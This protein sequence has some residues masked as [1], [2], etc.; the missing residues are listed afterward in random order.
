M[1]AALDSLVDVLGSLTPAV[2]VV[3]LPVAGSALLYT[4]VVRS[5]N[6]RLLLP[7]VL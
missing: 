6:T 1:G 7:V 2:A 4:I 3:A 5:L